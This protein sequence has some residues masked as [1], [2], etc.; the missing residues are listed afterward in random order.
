VKASNIIGKQ[1]TRLTVIKKL[2]GS[3]YLCRCDCGK[4]KKVRR[5]KLTTENT[6]SCGCLYRDVMEKHGLRQ[7]R[8]YNIWCCM[9]GRCNNPNH[10]DY[11]NYG[12]RG[13]TVC[14]EWKHFLKF[15]D[16]AEANGY[17]DS[18]SLDRINNNAGYSPENCRWETDKVQNN[19]RRNNILCDILGEKLTLPEIANR[20]NLNYQ[21]VKGR[22]RNGYR[23]LEL[24]R[25]IRRNI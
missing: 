14:G 8:L 12:G 16:W 1:F 18:L 11:P 6:R 4:E 2:E 24:I 5:D 17:D 19:N 22:Y 13:I 21:T 9:R 7:T 20:Y 23:G 15:Y 25:P 10:R 3:Y